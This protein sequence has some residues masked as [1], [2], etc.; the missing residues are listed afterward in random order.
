MIWKGDDFY[1]D[2]ETKITEDV[3]WWMPLPHFPK[4]AADDRER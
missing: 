2:P 1:L 4:E 3:K